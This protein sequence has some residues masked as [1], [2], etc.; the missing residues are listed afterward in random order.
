[1]PKVMN[2]KRITVALQHCIIEETY[3]ELMEKEHILA[4]AFQ[5]E[6]IGPWNKKHPEYKV[7]MEHAMVA[8]TIPPL[9]TEI[10]N[11]E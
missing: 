10:G 11:E 7:E 2:L 6:V 8:T 4:Q 5:E 3:E 1:M 9:P